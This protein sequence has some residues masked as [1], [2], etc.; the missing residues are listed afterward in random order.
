MLELFV[1]DSL[2]EKSDNGVNSR[3]KKYIIKDKNDE[4]YFEKSRS[5][6]DKAGNNACHF[7]FE[8]VRD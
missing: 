8:M 1:K 6:K 5:N 4:H 7:A 3:D 2:L